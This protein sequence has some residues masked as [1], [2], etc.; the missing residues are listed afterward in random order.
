MP[1]A[2]KYFK[3]LDELI[4]AQPVPNAVS[5]AQ[6][7]RM[8]VQLMLEGGSNPEL[9]KEYKRMKVKLEALRLLHQMNHTGD[10]EDTLSKVL[11]GALSDRARK[12]Q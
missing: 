5:D 4:K 8:L 12:D 3:N 10:Q 11:L 7:R 6:I 1:R 9:D 2:K